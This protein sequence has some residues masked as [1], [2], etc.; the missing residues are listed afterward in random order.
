MLAKEIVDRVMRKS[1][2]V[3][4]SIKIMRI[5]DWFATA[6][7][8]NVIAFQY[9]HPSIHLKAI[10]N[11]KEFDYVIRRWEE[12]VEYFPGLR[13]FPHAPVVVEEM[14]E[15]EDIVE[16][17]LKRRFPTKLIVRAQLVIF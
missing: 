7:I 14:I 2:E 6:K 12:A 3:G 8:S 13:K 15:A 9:Y 16:A 11:G 1:Y 17:E 4:S 10:G 5:E